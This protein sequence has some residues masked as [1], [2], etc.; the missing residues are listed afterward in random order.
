M[1][2]TFAGS[3]E[4][5]ERAR[6][7]LVHEEPDSVQC[8]S[9]VTPAVAREEVKAEATLFAVAAATAA[10]SFAVVGLTTV[11]MLI[12]VPQH[13]VAALLFTGMFVLAVVGAG[14]AVVWRTG[15]LTLR[16]RGLRRAGAVGADGEAIP[17]GARRRR[18]R[19]V[20]GV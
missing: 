12:A 18:R 10:G 9:E 7:S 11:V 4:S 19:R 8:I 1:F 2:D 15:A 5:D 17:A 13:W 14:V 16:G 3:T 6:L 20:S